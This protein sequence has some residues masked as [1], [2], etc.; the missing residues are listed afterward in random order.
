MPQGCAC[1][2]DM[3][4]PALL[5]HSCL[6]TNFTHLTGSESIL[7]AYLVKNTTQKLET[8]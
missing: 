4:F 7:F 1:T 2:E 5:G 8:T 6:R 3:N